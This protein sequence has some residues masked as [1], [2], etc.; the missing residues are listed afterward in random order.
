MIEARQKHQ[1]LILLMEDE[2]YGELATAVRRLKQPLADLTK[3]HE[4]FVLDNMSGI[5]NVKSVR[6]FRKGLEKAV[7]KQNEAE[8][9][10]RE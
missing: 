4:Q 8:K 7:E 3:L 6:D 2:V 9:A 1:H 5:N 10:R